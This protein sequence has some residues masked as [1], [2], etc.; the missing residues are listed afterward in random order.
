MTR[1]ARNNAAALAA[2]E[3]KRA[4]L[5]AVLARVT[6]HVEA[7]LGVDPASV[8]WG[9]VGD[10]EHYVSVAKLRLSD[11]MFGEGEFAA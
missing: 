2:W 7:G 10:M 4:E 1:T 9:N 3:A 8:T 11:N 6:A 5:L